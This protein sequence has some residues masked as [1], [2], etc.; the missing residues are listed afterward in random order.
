MDSTFGA[1][2]PL[3]NTNMTRHLLRQL[4]LQENRAEVAPLDWNPPSNRFPAVPGPFGGPGGAI[5]GQ[6]ALQ[7]DLLAQLVD[8]SYD[9]STL[10]SHPPPI[11][12]VVT[13]RP[14][15]FVLSLPES[16]PS[17]APRAINMHQMSSK[18]DLK[19]KPET[20]SS[21]TAQE[22]P[23]IK[24]KDEEKQSPSIKQEDDALSVAVPS[25]TLQDKDK[26]NSIA[27]KA[28]FP[29]PLLESVTSLLLLG[30]DS[31]ILPPPLASSLTSM[32]SSSFENGD[33][34]ATAFDSPQRSSNKKIIQ[35]EPIDLEKKDG[36][37]VVDTVM[38]VEL[39]EEEEEEAYDAD[40]DA[41]PPKK[42]SRRP[43]RNLIDPVEAIADKS[44]YSHPE[45]VARLS[46]TEMSNLKQ[47]VT[48][49][50]DQVDAARQLLVI[51]QRRIIM[52]RHNIVKRRIQ[53]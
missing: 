15:D 19:A 11:P 4:I 39:E 10:S 16:V 44:L 50:I 26:I 12:P 24:L 48:L 5:A 25:L 40:D 29:P 17:L 20:K 35:D 46:S 49:D 23:R 53:K 34:L 33:N 42:R 3:L 27:E 36:E 37:P 8:S 28:T 21:L 31:D 51:P 38:S 47:L 1:S 9:P 18:E 30:H 52:R 45:A 32:I 14:P 2:N 6:L 22:E 13:P 7:N 43:R 41:E